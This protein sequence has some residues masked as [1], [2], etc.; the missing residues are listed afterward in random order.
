MFAAVVS[1]RARS[2]A[3]IRCKSCAFKVVRVTDGQLADA[4]T[5]CRDVWPHDHGRLIQDT[6]T[7]ASLPPHRVVP[8]THDELVDWICVDPCGMDAASTVLLHPDCSPVTDP[9]ELTLRLTGFVA[10]LSI[11]MLGTWNG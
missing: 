10:E 1:H 8:D 5:L 11:G 3:F 9:V 2:M 4:N 7:L 6:S